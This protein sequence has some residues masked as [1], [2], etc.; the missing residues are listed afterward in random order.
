MHLLGMFCPNSS[1]AEQIVVHFGSSSNFNG[2]ITFDPAYFASGTSTSNTNATYTNANAI[3]SY[4]VL[5][6][7]TNYQGIQLLVSHNGIDSFDGTHYDGFTIYFGPENSTFLSLYYTAETVSDASLASGL[8][9]VN[10][11]FDG[12][13]S[14][15]PFNPAIIYGYYPQIIPSGVAFILDAFSAFTNPP[16]PLLVQGKGT[17]VSLSWSTNT[18]APFQLAHSGS[19]F[20]STWIAI[21]N[22][23]TI[24]NGQFTVMMPMNAPMD[25]FRLQKAN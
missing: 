13:L 6:A 1:Q 21:S 3:A 7:Q 12:H 18:F 10:K 22:T 25:F 15:V 4:V 11:G 14:R 5:G 19:A 9:L 2:T 16:P 24:T 23:P 17:N 8:F 20:G